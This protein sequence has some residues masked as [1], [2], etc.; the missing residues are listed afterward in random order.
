[1]TYNHPLTSIRYFAIMGK[2]CLDNGMNKLRNLT[3]LANK[4]VKLGHFGIFTAEDLALLLNTPVNHSFNKYLHKAVKTGV[5]RK[6]ARG[7]YYCPSAGMKAKGVLEY[8]AKL[9]HW[10]R[11]VY[12]SLESQLSHIGRISQL[13]IKRLTVMTTGRSNVVET[14]FGVIEFTHTSRDPDGLIDELY[15][16]AEVGLF[17]A[18]EGCAVR[19]LKRVGRNTHMLDVGE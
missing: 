17:R 12:I 7:L 15:F 19:D 16:D 1:M 8:I 5:L 4:A 18:K 3:E 6:V 14:P 13:P 11:F 9:L 10:N 2:I